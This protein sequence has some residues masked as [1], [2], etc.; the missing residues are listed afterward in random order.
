MVRMSDTIQPEEWS[1][2]KMASAAAV[3]ELIG[4]GP[5]GLSGRLRLATL[6]ATRWLRSGRF[7]IPLRNGGRV[8]LNRGTLASDLETLREMF[9]PRKNPYRADYEGAVVLDIGAHKGYFAAFA[10]VH[11]ARCVLSYEPASENFELLERAAATFRRRGIRWETRHAAVGEESGSAVLEVSA[12][13]WTHSLHALPQSGPARAVSS[14]VVEIVAARLALDEAGRAAS[15]GKLIVKIDAEGAECQ[16]CR[17]DATNWAPVSE[18]FVETHDSAP[19]EVSDLL[20]EP[21]RAGLAPL[22]RAGPVLRLSR[23]ATVAG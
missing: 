9:V 19:C 23:Q 10:L 15:G 20:A 6:Y 3:R 8:F 22:E 1:G 16:I 21:G 17:A 2:A 11:G 5:F 14:E 13:S 12:E 18:L 7:A 4:V